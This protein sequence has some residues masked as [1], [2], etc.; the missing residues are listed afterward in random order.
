MRYMYYIAIV[1]ALCSCEQEQVENAYVLSGYYR[2]D[3]DETQV[4]YYQINDE[5]KW[6]KDENAEVSIMATGEMRSVPFQSDFNYYLNGT[7][8]IAPGSEVMIE[9]STDRVIRSKAKVPPV[10]APENL[11]NPSITIDPGQPGEEVFNLHWN[12]EPGY[13]YLLRLECTEPSPSEIPFIGGGGFFEET[14]S[15]PIVE[16]SALIYASD[17]K[18]YGEHK[19]TVYILENEYANLFFL[20]NGNLGF[21]TTESP[22]NITGGK[23]Y[24]TCINAFE[25]ILQ[26]Q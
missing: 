14:F 9:V 18:F 2:A 17:F 12:A 19:I 1:M 21:L 11:G 4:F 13:S 7:N 24:W 23:G 5:G 20:R 15:R 8:A 16:N 22:D 25:V 6:L 10:I 3:T 26:V